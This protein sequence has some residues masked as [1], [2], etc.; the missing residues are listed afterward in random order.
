MEDTFLERKQ[1]YVGAGINT[2]MSVS[3]GLGP[4]IFCRKLEKARIMREEMDGKVVYLPPES[5]LWLW[6]CDLKSTFPFLYLDLACKQLCFPPWK[7]Y[8]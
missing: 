8:K 5:A 1:Y 2:M 7:R 6:S 4:Y 3:D